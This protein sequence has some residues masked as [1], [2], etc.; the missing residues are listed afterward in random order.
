LDLNFNEPIYFS[1]VSSP[2][3]AKMVAGGGAATRRNL[4]TA[5]CPPQFAH[6]NL[7]TAICPPQFIQVPHHGIKQTAAP[8]TDP[9]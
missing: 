2:Q 4:P 6:R 7:P 9:H 8:P 3:G 1:T 5:I